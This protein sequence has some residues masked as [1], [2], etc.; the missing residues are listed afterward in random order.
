MA[1]SLH[2]LKLFVGLQRRLSSGLA[3][4]KLETAKAESKLHEL[5][6][7]RRCD[8]TELFPV[9]SQIRARWAH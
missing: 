5:V 9:L 1:T 7:T 8:P 6:H 3:E 4:E 2:L